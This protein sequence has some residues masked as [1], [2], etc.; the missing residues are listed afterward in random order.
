MNQYENGKNSGTGRSRARSSSY[1][2]SG[3]STSAGRQART[4]T[5]SGRSTS[6]TSSRSG[7]AS[8]SSSARG[9]AAGAARRSSG[10]RTS[11]SSRTD[12]YYNETRR[13]SSGRRGGRRG[14]KGPDFVKIAVGGVILILAIFCVTFLMKKVTGSKPDQTEAQ[15]EITVPET[16]L[17]K[18]V[19]VDGINIT[20]MSRDEAKAA[21]LKDFPWAMKVTWQD[22]SYGVNDLM[23][24]KVD[25]LLQEIYTGEP[26]ESYTLDTTGLEDAVAK[27]AE[28]VAALW[29]K[30]AKNG[31]ISEYDSQN[32]KFLFK[33]AE[34]GLAVDQEQ[35]KADIQAALNRKDFSASIAA[36]VNEVEPEFSEATAREKYKTIG[37][38]TTNTTANQKRN[39]NVKLAAQAING[40]VLQP[41]EEFSF[42][43]RVGERTEA[44]GYQAA[45]A[46]NNGEVVQE[47]GGGVCQ[48]SSTMYNAV[49]KAGLKTTMR[50]S[51]TFEPS[52]VTP[53]TDATVSWGGPDYKFVNNSS[54]AIGIRASYYNQTCTVSI[55]GIP[56]LEDG[57]THSLKSTK[58]SETDPPAPTYEED[59]TLTP[60]TEKVKS[61]G[62]KGS[63]WE[64]RLIV[65]KN[66]EVVS[67]DV[68]H[69]VTYKGHTPVILRNSTGT[70][71]AGASSAADSSASAADG[72]TVVP[73][74]DAGT[75][76]SSAGES[77]K[78]GETTAVAPS[79]TAAEK[80]TAAETTA[81]ATTAASQQ[82]V[83]HP[84]V[85]DSG[86]SSSGGNSSGNAPTAADSGNAPTIAP[87][88]GV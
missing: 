29:N 22:Q 23:A 70:T 45:A 79:H 82:P 77:H 87:N 1:S 72:T 69:S 78:A 75:G 31:S 52:Y 16:E 17:E 14:G 54:A 88:P 62:S 67:Q 61:A 15:T 36:T 60:G 63:K 66:G 65:T 80:T 28:S 6:G 41:G 33:G 73:S 48:V 12:R 21:I 11:A 83:S 5:G 27:E 84:T 46:Y 68:D 58:L 40:I 25:A 32:D 50:R 56:V 64:T 18:E 2:G 49:V 24:E 35:L 44:K 20:G 42:N 86:N 19:T 85:A 71:A 59:P 30:K 76:T 13:T 4:T 7:A 34:N 51:H 8:R 74:G 43:N 47:I 10:S 38:F 39:T 26:K 81:Q 37:T 57:V 9:T 3:R 53:G 55:Y